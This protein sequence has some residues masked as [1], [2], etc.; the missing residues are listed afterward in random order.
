MDIAEKKKA[1][2]RQVKEQAEALSPGY[3]EAADRKINKLLLSLPEYRQART[4]FCFV[5]SSREIN[6][7]PFLRR[8]L[9]DRKT[10]AVP[11]CISRGIMEAREITSLSELTRGYCG[12]EE[13]SADSRRIEP[14]DIDLAVIPCV[15]CSHGGAR[16][17]HG[18]GYYDIYFS[19]HPVRHTVM[20]CYEK[21]VREDIPVEEHD[22][23]FS[24]VITEEGVFDGWADIRKSDIH[25]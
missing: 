25:K 2:R 15:S 9:S 23:V 8:V 13:P 19:R 18:G 3:R 1:L 11:L 22:L 4:V 17:G 20:I 21:I 5:G 12:L 14:S 6:T 7:K 16:L 24:R 10:L